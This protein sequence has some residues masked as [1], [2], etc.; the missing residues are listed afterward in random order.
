MGSSYICL[1]L[2]NAELTNSFPF[3]GGAYSI[4]RITLGSYPGFLI[5]C[6]EAT[7]YILYVACSA[8]FL[9]E[10]FRDVWE[11]EEFMVPIFCLLFYIS[12]GY[13]LIVGEPYFW[14]ISTFFGLSSLIILLVYCFGSLPFINMI[15]NTPFPGTTGSKE[16]RPQWFIGGMLG[17]MKSFPLSASFFFGVETLNLSASLVHEPKTVIPS[18]S[19]RCVLTIFAMSIFVLFVCSSLPMLDD[20]PTAK[21]GTPLSVGYAIMFKIPISYAIIF[22]IP[23]TYA[24]SYGIMFA[25]SRV[26]LSMSQSRLLPPILKSTYGKYKAPYAAIIAGS[27]VGYVICVM[28][29]FIPMFQGRLFSICTLSAFIAY[30][31]QFLGYI[32]FKI[33]YG[34][35]AKMCRSPLGIFGAIYGGIVFSVGIVAI[36]C[37]QGDYVAFI[38]I[39]VLLFMYTIYYIF[40]AN[41]KQVFS[42]EENIYFPMHVFK[43]K[44]FRRGIVTY[45]LQYIFNLIEYLIWM[46]ARADFFVHEKF[47]FSVRYLMLFHLF[48]FFLE[49]FSLRLRLLQSFS[50]LLFEFRIVCHPFNFLLFLYFFS[51]LQSIQISITSRKQ[52]QKR[53]NRCHLSSFP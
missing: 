7:Q 2:C 22:N 32:T 17:F 3:A 43:C 44:Y 42:P 8:M 9:C 25:F 23:A 18:G 49:E 28:V 19:V 29:Y 16:D 1:C 12:A 41:R 52:E 14:R 20:I 30:V 45:I 50:F 33:K 39:L 31:C 53:F 36:C 15:R 4:N 5:G 24:T 51:I 47:Y 21:L 6:C 26:L 37:F 27:T 34:H 40:Y 48:L 11:T 46:M 35:F 10:M 38:T 13:I